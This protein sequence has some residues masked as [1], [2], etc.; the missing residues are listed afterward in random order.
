[1]NVGL[2]M[3]RLTLVESFVG[4]ALMNVCNFEVFS[5]VTY[6]T[7]LANTSRRLFSYTLVWH[8]FHTEGYFDAKQSSE[9]P[10]QAAGYVEVQATPTASF[11]G[12]AAVVTQGQI[13]PKATK[14]R[15]QVHFRQ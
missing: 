5:C 7:G 15:V 1:M 12:T 14:N 8:S 9:D 13:V 3:S 10:L 2:C 11:A 4:C 6:G